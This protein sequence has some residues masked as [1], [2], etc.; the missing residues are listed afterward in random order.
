MFSQACND[1]LMATAKATEN[2]A[3]AYVPAPTVTTNVLAIVSL[4][5]G[6]AGLT[7][8]PFLGSIAAVVTGHISL[9]QLKTKQ[10]NGRGMAIAGLIT[11]Y[12]G[13]AF[14]VL[15]SI[16]LIAFLVMVLQSGMANGGGGMRMPARGFGA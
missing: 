10:E 5:T 7:F 4:V 16:L 12:V 11:G 6:I 2:E 13:V 3:P 15:A 8:V 1:G 14:T 9:H